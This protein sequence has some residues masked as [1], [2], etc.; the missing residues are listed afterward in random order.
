MLR[1]EIWSHNKYY[2][3]NWNFCFEIQSSY[4][5]GKSSMQILMET[6]YQKILRIIFTPKIFFLV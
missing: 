2:F 4:A 1:K 6:I 3:R 5:F